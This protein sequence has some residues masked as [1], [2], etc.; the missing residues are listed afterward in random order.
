MLGL[1]AMIFFPELLPVDTIHEIVSSTNAQ[2]IV[3]HSSGLFTYGAHTN[4]FHLRYAYVKGEQKRG[5][6]QWW[7]TVRGYA[8][9]HIPETNYGYFLANL[10][11]Y[12]Y[13]VEIEKWGWFVSYR[14]AAV[15][16]WNQQSFLLLPFGVRRENPGEFDAS[17][18]Y[19]EEP[20]NAAGIRLGWKNKNFY[21][22]YSQG[23]YRHLIPMGVTA[24]VFLPWFQWRNTLIIYNGEPETYH[25]NDYHGKVQSSLSTALKI[26][27]MTFFFL[28]EGHYLQKEDRLGVRMEEAIRLGQVQ[29]GCRQIWWRDVGWNIEGSLMYFLP[30]EEVALGMQASTEGKIYIGTRVDF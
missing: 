16:R 10:S 14:G 19:L 17:S 8:D 13:G 4:T 30:G 18:S 28:T 3:W 24:H 26:S 20:V 6:W 25:L 5:P 12:D 29:L 1:F 2:E 15:P 22:S 7:V 27:G 11:L 21:L 9:T 23:D